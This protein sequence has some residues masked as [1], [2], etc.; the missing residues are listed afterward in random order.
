[1]EASGRT[2]GDSAPNVTVIEPGRG[3]STS[4]LREIWQHRDLAYFLIRRNVAVRYKQAV[5]GAAWAILRP[6]LL[7]VVFSVFFGLLADVPSE[8]G[9]PYPLFALSGMTMWLL[10]S[11]AVQTASESMVSSAD[12]I[13]KVYF[14]RILIPFAAV[15]HSLIDFALGVVVVL[16]GLAIYGLMPGWQIVLLPF[17]A[18]FAFVAALGAGLWLS[19]LHVKYHDVQHMVP[20][21][22]LI[23]LFISPIV[24]PFSLVPSHLQPLY[25]LNPMVGPLELFRWVLFDT[26]WPGA[27]LAIPLTVTLLLAVTGLLY[28]QR[29]ERDFADVI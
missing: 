15:V 9:I 24:Y 14:P 20:F 21:V 25:A 7:A 28:F 22:L 29:A 27:V 6:V 8:S 26:P 5:I 1:M 2:H 12:L 11:G 23:G 17:V 18:L 3:W 10:F 16:V 19:A 13:E 4:E